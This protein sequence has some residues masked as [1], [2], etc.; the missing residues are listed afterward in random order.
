MKGHLRRRGPRSWCIVLEMGRDADGKRRQKW[1]T[2]HGTKAD[3]QREL[4]QLLHSVNTGTY[5]EPA[6]TTVA[7]YLDRWLEDSARSS[8]AAKTF[9]RYKEIV[10]LHLKPLLGHHRLPKLQPL[11][12]QSAY[13]NALRGGRKDGRPGGLSPQTVLHHHRVL[14]RAL[15][16]A[17]RW[18][19]LLRNPADAVEPPHPQHIEM[20]AIDEEQTALLVT[21][22][23]D[24]TSLFIPVLLAVTTGLRRGE[25]LGL[26]WEDVDLNAATL[27]VRQSLEQT[28]TGLSFK[29]PKTQKGR[30]VVTLPTLTVDALRRHKVEQAKLRLLLGPGYLDNGLVCAAPDGRPWN[31]NSFSHNCVTL[32][33]RAGL[34]GVRFHDLRHTHATQL[35]RQGIHP[36]VVSERLGHS[37]IGITLDVYSHVL[38]GMQEEAARRIDGALRRA[39]AEGAKK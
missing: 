23:R 5:V 27:A 37:T 2:V 34:A 22:A 1:H 12:I 6:R 36:K 24:T 7:D 11:H 16:Q 8:V 17:V 9:E 18:Q 28:K 38:P 33:R 30:R 10:N 14:H 13:L 29:Q 35:L 19:L 21:L 26:R 4:V 25:I 31:P 20:H 39:L 15:E 3:A 32:F